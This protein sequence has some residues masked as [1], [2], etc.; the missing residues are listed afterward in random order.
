[1]E[2]LTSYPEMYGKPGGVHSASVVWVLLHRVHD[3]DLLEHL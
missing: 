2:D 1:M 3:E